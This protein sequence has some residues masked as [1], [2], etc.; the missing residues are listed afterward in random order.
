M[1]IAPS[2]PELMLRW[3]QFGVFSPIFR[4]H[5]ANQDG[6]ERRIWKYDNF[7]QMLQCVDLRYQLM[8]YIY[9]AARQ[10]YDTGVSICRPLYYEWPEENEAYRQEGEYMF[11]DHIL[12][13]PVVTASDADGLTFHKTWLPQGQWYDVCRNR[14]LDGGQTISDLY[15]A[16]EIP[17]FIKAGSIVVCNPKM[18]NLKT[19]PSQMVLKVV[20]G[21][22]G[23]TT[24]YEDEGDTQDYQ[25][26]A[27]TTTHIS[28]QRSAGGLLLTIAPR[29]G[30]YNGMPAERA[31]EVV[32]LLA[33]RPSTVT[34]NGEA[35]QD[36]TYDDDT[37]TLTLNI[38]TSSCDSRL[39]VSVDNA[40]TGIASTGSVEMVAE[41]YY[42][43]MGRE[44]PRKPH[45]SYI[46]RR[47]WSNGSVSTE[48][49][50]E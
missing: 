6:N 33:E 39:E 41:R 8:P 10:A 26:G 16:H 24:L 1:Q 20:P 40:S 50:V 49:H 19:A 34:L 7:S 14:M 32:V 12:V 45:G 48:K 37:K 13:S 23:E 4:T 22:Q 3:L 21:E 31:Y 42:D 27:Y 47:T 9:T 46:V 2:D 29:Q 11:G 35:C 25:D 17:Y 43:L 44:H 28:Q 18:A 36:W 5:G 38:P 15:A 30:S